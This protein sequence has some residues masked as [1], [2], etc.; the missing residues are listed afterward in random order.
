MKYLFFVAVAVGIL[1]GTTIS[2]AQAQTTINFARVGDKS[3]PKFIENIEIR[4]NVPLVTLAKAPV[5]IATPIRPGLPSPKTNSSMDNNAALAIEACTP[6]QFKYAMLM[7]IEVELVRNMALFNFIEEWWAVRYRY[8]GTTKRGVD[9]SSYTGHLLESVYGL[10]L[11]RTAREQFA[12]TQRIAREDLLEGDLVFFNT[13][14]GISHVGVYLGND[15][16]THSSSHSG[17]TISSLT[18]PYYSKRYLGA[19]RVSEPVTEPNAVGQ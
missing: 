6:V 11:P 15:H 5:V 17:V 7:D 18:D 2:P 10:T 14:G 13:R 3:Q 8:G 1:S 19:G 16:F 12:K 4:R 9:C